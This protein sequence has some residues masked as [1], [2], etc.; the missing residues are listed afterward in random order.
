[1]LS[2]TAWRSHLHA[3]PRYHSF[4]E[5]ATKTPCCEDCGHETTCNT[6]EMEVPSDC[7]R[8]FCG[9]CKRRLEYMDMVGM[10]SNAQSVRCGFMYCHCQTKLL[11]S[12]EGVITETRARLWDQHLQTRDK[13]IRP[14]LW[15]ACACTLLVLLGAW[16][17]WNGLFQT[18]LVTV[19]N[20]SG[21]FSD[22]CPATY[23]ICWRLKI[24]HEDP[25]ILLGIL[26]TLLF[27]WVTEI[28]L[29]Y[30]GAAWGGSTY[31]RYVYDTEPYANIIQRYLPSTIKP[32]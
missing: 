15:R 32:E 12:M 7:T 1:M 29:C 13:E 27:F 5:M 28:F 2:K 18:T 30:T 23:W 17:I 10:V 19:I 24:Y 6:C 4:L 3:H 31:G 25:Y 16:S 8:P 14:R 22:E 21:W 11:H 26:V 20:R 9:E